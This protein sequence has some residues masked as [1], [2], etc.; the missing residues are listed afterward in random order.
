MRITRKSLREI[1]FTDEI[2]GYEIGFVPEDD[3][4]TDWGSE[5]YL[6]NAKVSPSMNT[7]VHCQFYA[8]PHGIM[9]VDSRFTLPEFKNI[10]RQVKAFPQMNDEKIEEIYDLIQELGKNWVPGIANIIM[11]LR[12]HWLKPTD[13][14]L[15]TTLKNIFSDIGPEDL[16]LMINQIT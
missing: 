1:Q 13:E 15:L 8:G 6:I 4:M 12:W 10:L 3:L 7:N 14:E 5:A 9:N 11:R 16:G 2:F